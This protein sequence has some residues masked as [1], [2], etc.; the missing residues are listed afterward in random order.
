MVKHF[1][2]TAFISSVLVSLTMSPLSLKP[3][4]T[5][6]AV[7]EAEPAEEVLAVD[8]DGVVS[9]EE[10]SDVVDERYRHAEF[11][12]MNDDGEYCYRIDVSDLELPEDTAVQYMHSFTFEHWYGAKEL[13][14]SMTEF[15]VYSND[16]VAT[17]MEVHAKRSLED[18]LRREERIIGDTQGYVE[19]ASLIVD[20]ATRARYLAGVVCSLLEYDHAYYVRDAYDAS[21]SGEGVCRAYA[22]LYHELCVRSGLDCVCIYGDARLDDGS[23]EKHAWNKVKVDGTWL[24]VDTTWADSDL[25]RDWV[26]RSEDW[27]YE[28]GHV[29]DDGAYLEA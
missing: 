7:V 23:V 20:E 12:G 15:F 4:E 2:S 28:V 27:F 19:Q 11:I 21:I 18:A 3:H 1:F 13:R 9:F 14:R 8:D 16:G 10:F 24:C 25:S 26:L 17:T 22:E 5:F 29:A 6:A